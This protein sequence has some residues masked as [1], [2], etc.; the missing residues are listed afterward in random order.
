[1]FKQRMTTLVTAFYEIPSKRGAELYFE[2]AAHY[3]SL[4][5][6][7]VLFTSAKF[8]ERFRAMRGTKP[9]H[10]ITKEFAELDTWILYEAEWK[11]HY[12][13]DHERYHS[14]ELYAVW[15][16]K[17][18]FV[19]EAIRVN[20][21]QTEFFFWCDIGAF[22]QPP[23]PVIRQTFPHAKYLSKETVLLSAVNP[24]QAKDIPRQADGCFGHFERVN[25]LVGGLW[26]GGAT[27]CLNWKSAFEA[28]LCRHF[29]VNRF[30]GKDQTVML[31]THIE[32]P[33]L[34]R[35]VQCTLPNIDIWFFLTYLLSDLEVSLV[36][37]KSYEIRRVAPVVSVSIKGGLGN[38]LF[39]V[40]SCFGYARRTETR[41]QLLQNK[42]HPD[43]RDTYWPSV[44]RRWRH[45]LVDTLP[46]LSK[47]NEPSSSEYVSL[48]SPGNG[49][50][51]EAYLQSS[52]YFVPFE[53]ELRYL[54]RANADALMRVRN[55]YKELLDN[56]DRVVVVHA[57]RTDYC[58]PEWNRLF[59]GPLTT[60]YY[61]QALERIQTI[62]KDPLF[63]LCS[64]DR[65]YWMEQLQHHPVLQ[66]QP[67]V[68]LDETDVDTLALFQHF[69]QFILANSTFSWWG[70]WLADAPHVIAPAKWFGPA[71]KQRYEDIYER[72]WIRI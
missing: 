60:D 11:Q 23:H 55:K 20:P 47:W 7:I 21:F 32:W 15:A 40:A 5:A 22:R 12:Q 27:A 34:A 4:E 39:E 38:Q 2:W 63:V 48:P 6:P 30:A 3:M 44:L 72:H 45:C 31:A 1:L 67:F 35:F 33:H 62:V 65:M 36:Y 54:L 8:V 57:R 66:T 24:L 59:H 64:D 25:Q 56:V 37:D 28:M 13:M 51:L 18:F 14:P 61:K 43:R 70:A 41:L 52:R 53:R 71:C 17:P 42:L 16:Q 29:A 9:L 49:M 26:G 50:Y 10:V 68:L 69:K 19:E 46:P 58:T